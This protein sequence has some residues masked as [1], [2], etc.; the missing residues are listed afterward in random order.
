MWSQHCKDFE[1]L[2]NESGKTETTITAYS[3]DLRQFFEYLKKK[4]IDGISTVSRSDIKNF[5]KHLRAK[6]YSVKSISR[7]LNT[8]RTFYRLMRSAGK[9]KKDPASTIRHPKIKGKPPRVLSETEYLALKE[10]CRA[11]KRLFAAVE[12]LL[13]TGVKIGELTRLE[14]TDLKYKN[15]KPSEIYVSPYH[16]NAGRWIPLNA[17]ASDA[18]AAYFKERTEGKN[19]AVFVSS[20]DR[21]VRIRNLRSYIMRAFKKAAIKNAKVNDLR[22]TFI[23]QQLKMGTNLTT[24]SKIVGHKRLSTTEKYLALVDSESDVMPELPEL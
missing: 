22:N 15:K 4:K 9:V 3:G 7:K 23:V 2:L 11:N 5:M 12:L 14:T 6:N 21:P 24:V 13:Q 16:N 20:R 18:L 17:K 1:T 8:I 10:V 19:T